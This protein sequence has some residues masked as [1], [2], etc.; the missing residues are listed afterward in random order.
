MNKKAN[1]WIFILCATVF[2]ILLTVACFL[3][4][5]LLFFGVIVPRFNL[6]E[7]VV[8]IG[9]IV[10]FVGAIAASFFIYK[11]VLSIISK[12]IDMEEYFDPLFARKYKPK[13]KD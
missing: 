12:K 6:A 1:T 7:N 2:N 3:L 4:L 10:V 11:F 9:M 8:T 5:F 13:K